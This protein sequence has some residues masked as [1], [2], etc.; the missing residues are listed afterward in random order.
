MDRGR[1]V[2]IIRSY[3][4]S[5]AYD[6]LKAL[7]RACRNYYAKDC[8]ALFVDEPEKFRDILL[9]YNDEST[10]KFVVKSLFL[11]PLLDEL[12]KTVLADE[13]AEAFVRDP[14]EFR[15]RLASLLGLPS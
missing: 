10:T 8:P 12:G 3:I 13:L 15:K 11:K 2:E 4:T 14:A 6:F 7:D 9:R 1:A 5:R